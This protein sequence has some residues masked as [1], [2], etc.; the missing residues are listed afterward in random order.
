MQDVVAWNRFGFTK[1]HKAI[2]MGIWMEIAFINI[3]IGKTSLP[4][5]EAQNVGNLVS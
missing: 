2:I 4:S 3:E 5:S 1:K